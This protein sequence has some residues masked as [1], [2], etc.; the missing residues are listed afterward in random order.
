MADPFSILFFGEAKGA[1]GACRTDWLKP[2]THLPSSGDKGKGMSS[3]TA[4]VLYGVCGPPEIQ[5]YQAAQVQTSPTCAGHTDLGFHT[6]IPLF[7]A[8]T[9][10]YRVSTM[11]GEEGGSR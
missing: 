6:P 9:N 5:Q 2:G 10:I 3:T 4:E 8:S 7:I 11:G 1:F